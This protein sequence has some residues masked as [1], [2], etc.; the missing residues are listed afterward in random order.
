MHLPY[1]VQQRVAV[2]EQRLARCAHL[3]LVREEKE[4]NSSV[5]GTVLLVEVE[6]FCNCVLLDEMSH[7]LVAVLC[8]IGN[9]GCEAAVELA[10]KCGVVVKVR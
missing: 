6:Y 4:K 2:H 10:N 9:V 3:P 1:A 5:I 8:H 7:E